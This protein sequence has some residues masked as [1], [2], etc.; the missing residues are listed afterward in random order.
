MRNLFIGVVS[1]LI[2]NSAFAGQI[3][4]CY[5]QLSTPLGNLGSSYAA[6]PVESSTIIKNCYATILGPKSN[7]KMNVHML[8]EVSDKKDNGYD[9]CVYNIS[10]TENSKEYIICY[11]K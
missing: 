1:L 10:K 5:H 11:M 4:F 8:S 7:D 6:T 9:T 3:A 2:S